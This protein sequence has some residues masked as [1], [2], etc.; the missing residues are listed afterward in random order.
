MNSEFKVNSNVRGLRSVAQSGSRPVTNDALQVSELDLVLF[1][2]FISDLD[3]GIE[4][5]LIKYSN[6]VKLGGVADTPEG[7]V[8]TGILWCIKKNMTSR[9][10]E[11][12]LT[13]YS[14]L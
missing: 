11:V 8:T 10:V 1:N 7:C 3:E 2:I 13:L 12:I 14:A 9:S 4:C 6:D 5:T